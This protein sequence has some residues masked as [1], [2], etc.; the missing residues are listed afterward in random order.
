MGE[1]KEK[2]VMESLTFLLNI[3]KVPLIK[4]IMQMEQWGVGRRNQI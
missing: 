1:S 3:G 2:K 4:F